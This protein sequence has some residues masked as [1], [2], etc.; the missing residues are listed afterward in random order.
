MNILK[1]LEEKHSKL[2]T[3][4]MSCIVKPLGIYSRKFKIYLPVLN[5]FII[6][7]LKHCIKQ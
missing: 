1:Y 5:M 7:L 4:H 2:K 6:I 3:E